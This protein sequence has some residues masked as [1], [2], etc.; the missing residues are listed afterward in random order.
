MEPKYNE[1]IIKFTAYPVN[2]CRLQIILISHNDIAEELQ[3]D[4]NTSTKLL[5]FP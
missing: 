3:L 2:F 4:R 1:Y 5:S